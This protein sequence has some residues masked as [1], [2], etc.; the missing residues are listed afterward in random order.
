MVL[1][2]ISANLVPIEAF[3]GT[4][5]SSSLLSTGPWTLKCYLKY[6]SNV[7]DHL[8]EL[9]TECVVDGFL[10]NSDSG[11]VFLPGCSLD[12]LRM[13]LVESSVYRMKH[14]CDNVSFE[15]KFEHDVI[16]WHVQPTS[17]IMVV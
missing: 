5:V 10:R 8:R 4:N 14:A 12:T 13:T 3:G 7:I 16:Y 17:A 9:H 1:D 6:I 11:T 2:A 15:H